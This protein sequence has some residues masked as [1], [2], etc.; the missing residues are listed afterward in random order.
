MRCS[1]L[2]V[3][4]VAAACGPAVSSGSDSGSGSD[5]SSG[6]VDESSGSSTTSGP[7]PGT[8]E[9]T[10]T[11]VDCTV[12]D[13]APLEGGPDTPIRLQND[14]EGSVL[15]EINCGIDYLRLQ[16]DQG[17][18]WPGPFCSS[19]CE[20]QLAW[21]CSEC[22][23]C[24]TNSYLVVAPGELVELQWGGELYEELLPDPACI[25]EY[26]LCNGDMSCRQRQHGI[27]GAPLFATVSMVRQSVCEA[28]ALDP[29]QCVCPEPGSCDTHVDTENHVPIP[30]ETFEVT[31]TIGEVFTVTFEAN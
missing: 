7:L 24:A 1:W 4:L 9:S 11:P 8:S 28:H 16:D 13:D 15:L 25:G 5:S 2:C 23:G 20:E 27:E 29:S 30:L 14:S 31:G 19:T 21:G 6:A 17:R 18:T 12:Y 3:A 22:G 26:G 10:G